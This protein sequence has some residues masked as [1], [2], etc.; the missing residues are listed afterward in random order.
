MSQLPDPSHAGPLRVLRIIWLALILGPLVFLIVTVTVARREDVTPHAASDLLFYMAL[1]MAA[2][3]IPIAFVVRRMMYAKGRQPDGTV[4][5]SAY[6]SGTI[7]F[8]AAC[9][10]VAMFAIAGAFLDGG[11]GA[12]LIIAAL[13]L[14]VQ[15]LSFPTGKPLRGDDVLRPIDRR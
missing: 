7:L 12:H 4:A 9:D 1:G 13:A 5:L 2:A 14:G 15:V 8:L 6:S 10:G 3:V 11:R